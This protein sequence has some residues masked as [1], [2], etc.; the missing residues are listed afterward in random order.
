MSRFLSYE[1]RSVLIPADAGIERAYDGYDLAPAEL[2]SCDLRTVF[3][4]MF[5]SPGDTELLCIGPPFANIGRP[6]KILRGGSASIRFTVGEPVSGEPVAL[7]RVELGGDPGPEFDLRFIF[8]D[9]EADV[10]VAPKRPAALPKVSLVLSTTQKDNDPQWVEDWC[11]WHRR[12][13]GVERI[14][15]YDNG[16]ANADE[17]YSGSPATRITTWSS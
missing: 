17:T 14:V 1:P 12:A 16:S 8:D 2:A 7:T 4:D 6:R 13:H 15:I 5:L 11:L 3:S 9:F 10:H